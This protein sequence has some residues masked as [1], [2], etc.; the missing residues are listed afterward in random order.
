MSTIRSDKERLEAS[1]GAVEPETS[2]SEKSCLRMIMSW[3]ILIRKQLV[4]LLPGEVLVVCVC[5]RLPCG[6][7]LRGPTEG[8]IPQGKSAVKCFFSL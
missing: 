6:I 8:G 4:F 7:P 3:V 1:R 2:G 5:L